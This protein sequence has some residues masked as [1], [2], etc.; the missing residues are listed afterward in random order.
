MDTLFDD[1]YTTNNSLH[2]TYCLYSL[3]IILG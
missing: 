3:V 2:K 1:K